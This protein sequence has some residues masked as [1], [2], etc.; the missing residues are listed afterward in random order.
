LRRVLLKITNFFEPE[1]LSRIH[2][3]KRAARLGTP[4][5]LAVAL[6]FSLRFS[7]SIT[8]PNPSDKSLGYF[9]FVR[10]AD[11]MHAYSL[12]KACKGSAQHKRCL[13]QLL[14]TV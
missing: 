2:H 3:F 13:K 5:P 6:T 9:H 8:R 10:S 7:D 14:A 4:V 11:D 12:G 1:S